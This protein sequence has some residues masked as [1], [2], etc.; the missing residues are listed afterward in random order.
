MSMVSTHSR[1]TGQPCSATK[2]TRKKR[3]CFLCQLLFPLS[4]SV[5]S[6]TLSLK[7]RVQWKHPQSPSPQM[8]TGLQSDTA[9]K[10]SP[11]SPS[12]PCTKHSITSAA[13]HRTGTLTYF[14]TG[15]HCTLNSCEHENKDDS[16]KRCCL[17]K[18]QEETKIVLVFSHQIIF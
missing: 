17:P 13:R 14:P 3:L 11:S 1:H 5:L 15:S 16:S 10:A 2:R 8:V 12:P 4:P 6:L 7:V 18:N 9:R